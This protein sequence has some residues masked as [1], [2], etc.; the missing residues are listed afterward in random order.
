MNNADLLAQI[1]GGVMSIEVA[2][3]HK[4]EKFDSS[5]MVESIEKTYDALVKKLQN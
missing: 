4:G 3:I 1:T 5:K 2:K